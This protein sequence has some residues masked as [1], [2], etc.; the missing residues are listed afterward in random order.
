MSSFVPIYCENTEKYNVYTG[1]IK[2]KIYEQQFLFS[3]IFTC[4]SAD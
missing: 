1:D 3:L 2:I 4:M